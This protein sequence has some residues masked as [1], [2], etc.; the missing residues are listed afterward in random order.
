MWIYYDKMHRSL[1]LNAVSL[2]IMNKYTRLQQLEMQ[3]L[4]TALRKNSGWLEHCG[5]NFI[6]F[7]SG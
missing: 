3:L 5:C 7:G 2:T 6:E 1:K 4:T